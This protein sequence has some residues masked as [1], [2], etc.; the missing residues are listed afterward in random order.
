MYRRA[1]RKDALHGGVFGCFKAPYGNVFDR[2]TTWTGRNAVL[3]LARCFAVPGSRLTPGARGHTGCFQS[4]TG[5]GEQPSSTVGTPHRNVRPDEGQI[6]L[7][8]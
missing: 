8:A 5:K 3:L 6:A 7:L 4:R 2:I 1:V